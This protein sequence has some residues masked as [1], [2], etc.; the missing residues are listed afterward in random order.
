[1]SDIVER[2]RKIPRDLCYTMD[3]DAHETV[4]IGELSH[5]AADLVEQLPLPRD[6]CR[7]SDTRD[8]WHCEQG[9]RPANRGQSGSPRLET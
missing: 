4:P 1:M 6:S 8:L 9:N 2:L 7:T 5:L 3:T